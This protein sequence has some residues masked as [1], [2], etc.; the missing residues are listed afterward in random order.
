MDEQMIEIPSGVQKRTRHEYSEDDDLSNHKS[1]NNSSHTRETDKNDNLKW[2]ECVESFF[3]SDPL[4]KITH[5]SDLLK[6]TIS[7]HSHKNEMYYF[8]LPDHP[9]VLLIGDQVQKNLKIPIYYELLM[10]KVTNF[11]I[12]DEQSIKDAAKCLFKIYTQ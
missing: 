1:N 9:L 6:D 12:I 8:L 5:E 11:I 7:F 2:K 10:S 4:S 3:S